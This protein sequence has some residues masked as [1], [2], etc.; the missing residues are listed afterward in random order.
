MKKPALLIVFLSLIILG[1]ALV[2]T[3]ISNN[4]VTSGVA[5]GKIQTE[6]DDYKLQNSILAEQL[7]GLSSLTNLAQ[8]AYDQGYTEEESS[9]VLSQKLPVA[10]KQ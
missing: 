9:L 10:I 2:R 1:L 8:K 6:I 5:L 4:V 3:N 7:F